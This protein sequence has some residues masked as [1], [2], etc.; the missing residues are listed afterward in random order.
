MASAQPCQEHFRLFSYLLMVIVSIAV[1]VGV[2][3]MLQH[4]TEEDTEQKALANQESVIENQELLL[5]LNE[6][7]SY[8]IGSALESQNNIVELID[9]TNQN[10][11]EFFQILEDLAT[12]TT[13]RYDNVTK[14]A[15]DLATINKDK[16]DLVSKK[17]DKILGILNSSTTS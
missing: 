11:T 14:L 3:L 13:T 1:I 16:I 12:N 8:A 15:I 10:N 2:F 6:N 17:M 4:L 5:S 7:Q 9:I